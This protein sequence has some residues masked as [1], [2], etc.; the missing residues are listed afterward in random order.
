MEK[1]QNMFPN[2]ARPLLGVDVW[3]H[4]YYLRYQNRRSDYIEAFTK[5]INWPM[6]DELFAQAVEG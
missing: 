3:E 6:V 5:V 4:A 1:Q 2:G